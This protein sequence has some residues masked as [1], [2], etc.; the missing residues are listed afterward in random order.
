MESTVKALVIGITVTVVGGVIAKVI[1]NGYVPDRPTAHSSV[2]VGRPRR[3]SAPDL[4]IKTG[5]LHVAQGRSFSFALGTEVDGP[6]DLQLGSGG[7][8]YAPGILD[9]GPVS[10]DSVTA[11]PK[12]PTS[13]AR[14]FS[15]GPYRRIG[16]LAQVG[17]T[18]ALHLNINSGPYA[19]I[20]VTAVKQ[21]EAQASVASILGLY[22]FQTNGTPLF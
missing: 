22:R 1:E 19:T 12:A 15:I 2:S 5:D 16:V 4:G 8:L 20:Q 13:L 6:S 11:V 17:H 3:S 9:L 18:Y 14:H 7:L 21:D 10:I